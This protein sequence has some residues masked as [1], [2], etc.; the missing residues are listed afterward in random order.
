MDSDKFRFEV[1]G[2]V[3]QTRIAPLLPKDWSEKEAASNAVPNFLWEN[4]PRRETRGYRDTVP[5]YSHLPNGSSIL[6]SKWVLGR[7]LTSDTSEDPDLAT[8]E[9]HCFRG[10]NGFRSFCTQEKLLETNNQGVSGSNTSTETPATKF[11]DILNDTPGTT[12]ESLPDPPSNLWFVKD[13]MSNGA[14]GVWVVGPENALTFGQEGTSPLYPE[15]RYVAQRYTWPPVLFGGRKSHVRVYGL[16]TSDGRAFVHQRAFLHVA[17]DPF[18]YQENKDSTNNTGTFRDSVHVTNCCANSHDDEKFAGEILADFGA[19][20]SSELHNHTVVPLAPFFPSIR[21]SVA[22]LAQR[23]FPFLRGG[24]ANHGF[25]YLGM[26][27]ILSYREGKPVAY[28]LEVN[29]PPSQDTA[30]GLPH[31]EDLHDTV[32][33]D[34]LSLWVLPHIQPKQYS[35]RPG[36]WQC[37]YEEEMKQGEGELI[38]PSKASILNK[39]RWTLFEK[40]TQKIEQE[41]AAAKEEDNKGTKHNRKEDCAQIISNF[42]RTQF[43]YFSGAA[44]SQVFFENAG[45]SQVPQAVVQAVSASLVHRNR[46]IMGSKTKAAARETLRNILGASDCSVLLGSNATS[47]LSTLAMQYVRLGLLTSSDEVVISTENH[48]ANVDP[49]VQAARQV[50]ATIKWWT[51]FSSTGI[52]GHVS[53][54]QLMDLVSAKT[55]VVALSHASNILGQ[56]RNVAGLSEQIK[57]KSNGYA[58]V[59]VDGVA[60]APHWYPNVSKLQAV[61]WYVV[62]CHKLFGPHLGGLCGRRE[63]ALQEI[64][65]ASGTLSEDDIFKLF[66]MGTVN[67]EACAGVVGLGRYLGALSSF[68]IEKYTSEDPAHAE[69]APYQSSQALHDRTESMTL[70]SARGQEIDIL[71]AGITPDQ[72]EEAYRRITVAEAPLVEALLAGLCRSSKVHVVEG[73]SNLDCIVRLPVVGFVHDDIQARTILSEC[74]KSGIAIRRSSFLCTEHLARDFGFDQSEGILRVSLAHYNTLPE[75]HLLIRMLESLPKWF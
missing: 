43:P 44:S 13:D 11:P 57:F 45:G 19:T 50:G 48:V 42:A 2:S 10:L 34:L 38:A 52:D 33:S 17:N 28:M 65:S 3:A 62:S 75:I 59:V 71:R 73:S 55:R 66:E 47:L 60:A 24:Q 29:A 27:F 74:D 31:A 51:P 63:G 58:H 5:V 30:T 9:T 6:D 23:T 14:G 8:L 12:Y 61:D 36:G 22:A 1:T 20:K 26:D 32:I 54:T 56:I 25:E 46:S 7:L 35:E 15:H 21:A 53:S 40:K 64:M 67:Y 70:Y 39:I 68:P 16:L 37:V 72:V 49:W 4:A 41:A 18:M 69:Q